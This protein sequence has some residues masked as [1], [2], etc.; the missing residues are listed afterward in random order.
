[1]IITD[2]LVMD[3]DGIEIEADAYGNNLAF[4]CP[5]CGHPV[6]A[7]TLEN[8]RGSDEQC[9]ATCKGCGDQYFL[10]VRLRAEKIYIHQLPLGNA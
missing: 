10:D 5:S 3:G 2:F 7:I 4:N 6:L 1:M 9:P 8:Q